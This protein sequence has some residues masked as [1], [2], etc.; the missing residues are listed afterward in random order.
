MKDFL[1]KVGL[2]LAILAGIWVVFTQLVP[3]RVYLGPEYSRWET[4]FA[5]IEEVKA[6]AQPVNLVIGD[7]RPQMGLAS[8]QLRAWNYALGGTSPVEGYYMLRQLQDVPIDTVY[9]SYSAFHFHFQ[10]CF[11]TRSEYFGFIDTD[12]LQE[13]ESLSLALQDTVFQW[14][15]W[16]WLDD[17]DANFSSPWVR[18]QFRYLLP[19][20]SWDNWRWYF[21]DR[22]AMQTKM[23]ENQLSYLFSSNICPGDTSVQEFYLEQNSGGF[24]VNPVNAAYFRKMLAEIRRRDIHL[25]WI[26]MPLNNA[27]RQPSE[28]YYSD[29]ERWVRSQLPAGTAYH[30]LGM[31]DSCDFKD[32]SH[33]RDVAAMD[34]TAGIAA[35]FGK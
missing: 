3:K 27:V 24:L 17:L 34:F 9:L 11:H 31:R 1:K 18:R 7:S 6:A 8:K 30:P 28:S 29:F 25:V 22:P 35:A 13:V 19:L 32:F 26:N 16:T 15:N 10:D 5:S 12:Y 14:N 23:Q 20:R 33:L 4:V 21:K 2:R